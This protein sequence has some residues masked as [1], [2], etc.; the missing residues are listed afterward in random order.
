MYAET[1]G[2]VKVSVIPVYLAGQSDPQ[3][4]LYAWA[5][6]ITILNLSGKA[7]RLLSRHWKIT[8]GFG[9]L[10]EVRGDGV[11][12]VQPLIPPGGAFDYTSGV[13]LKTPTGIMLGSYRMIAENGD[14]LDVS[15]PAFSLDAPEAVFSLN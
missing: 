3:E 13:S 12:G 10:Q 5:Y 2:E 14:V 7:V 8:D 4:N 6:N 1:T 9:F 15:I 11:V